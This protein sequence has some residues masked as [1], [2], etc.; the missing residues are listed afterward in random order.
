MTERGSA[1]AAAAAQVQ[2]IVAAAEQSAAALEEAARADAE[3]VRSEADR[4]AA[5]SREAVDRVAERADELER[6]L[7]DLAEA[8]RQGV[9]GL[10]SELE[11]LRAG[12]AVDPEPSIEA[13]EDVDEDLIAEVEEVAAKEPD[14][15]APEQGAAG[16]PAAS[17]G[18]RLLALKM[19]LDGAPREDTA[20]YLRENFELDDAEALLDEVYAKAGR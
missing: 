9:A 5:A 18:A 12:P 8:V 4:D 6:R 20:R 13:A 17:E 16:A 14:V 2:A 19:A 10:R 1:A 3:R 15:R 11:A 7:E